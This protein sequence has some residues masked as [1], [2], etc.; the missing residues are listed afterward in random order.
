ME[1]EDPV[2]QRTRHG[3]GTGD[4][5]EVADELARLLDDLRPV[6]AAGPLVPGDHR[7]RVQRFD[8][9]QGGDPALPG[10]RGGLSEVEV[11]VVAG[12]IG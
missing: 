12:G 10:Q 9:V 3:G 1:G 8:H 6:G 7:S 5:V 2:I 11:D 4:G